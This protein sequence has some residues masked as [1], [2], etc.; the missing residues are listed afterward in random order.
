M[1]FYDIYGIVGY[2]LDEVAHY[3]SGVLDIEL[4]RRSSDFLGDF[5][6]Y[7]RGDGESLTLNENYDANQGE[8]LMPDHRDQTLLLYVSNTDRATEIE[9]RLLASELTV[10]LLQRQTSDELENTDGSGAW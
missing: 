2:G 8:Y 10:T 9:E 5:Y 1:R 6:R 4:T 7:K 3:L